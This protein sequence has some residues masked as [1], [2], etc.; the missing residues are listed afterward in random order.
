MTPDD[1]VTHFQAE[2]FDNLRW[3]RVLRQSKTPKKEADLTYRR[4]WNQKGGEH[5]R[6]RDCLIHKPSDEKQSTNAEN[7]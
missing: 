2:S 3:R 4:N 1:L 6:R 5:D 7:P